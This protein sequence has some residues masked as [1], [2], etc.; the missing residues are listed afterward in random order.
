MKHIFHITNGDYLAEELKNTSIKGEIIVCREALIT[1]TL[2]ADS[3]EEFWEVRAKSIADDYNVSEK[4]YYENSVSEFEKI[5]NIPEGSEVNLWFEDDLFCQVN[6]WFCI[7]LLSK[8]DDLKI[9][10]VFP[11]IDAENYWK[12]FS[13]SNHS[14]LEDLLESKVVFNKNDIELTLK[15]WKAY[16]NNDM[17]SL[18]QLSYNQSNCFH[19]LKEVTDAYI[20]IKPENFI[21]NQIENGLT[22]F[23]SVFKKFQKELGIFGFGDLQVRN[24]YQKL[25]T[26]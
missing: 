26:Q 21:R 5:L 15:L 14:D 2:K 13:D 22:D 12:G 11:K 10:R 7:S 20:N 18:K 25:S 9:Y 8:I 16:Q 24:I 23:D 17:D 4:S 3:L 19:F 6:L 1:G